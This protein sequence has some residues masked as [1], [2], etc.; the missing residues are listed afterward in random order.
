MEKQY[1]Y[2]YKIE[3]TL[4][5]KFYFGVHSTNNLEDNYF[6]S[7]KRL[8]YAIKKYGKENF[9]KENLLFFET[10]KQAFDYEIEIVNE[11]LLLDPS[12]YNLKV[13]GKGGLGFISDEQQLRRA[14]AASAAQRHKFFNDPIYHERR[15]QQLSESCKKRHK[16][17]DFD[18]NKRFKDKLHTKETKEL[19]GSKNKIN[20]SGAGNSQYGTCWVTNKKEN[21]KIHRGDLIPTGWKLG[22]TLE[23]KT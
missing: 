23:I 6:G 1:N 20:Q 19:I 11:A 9:I 8:K 17:G 10:Y 21:K 7:G 3:N 22:R 18:N 14:K 16:N 12:C 15:M 2:F 4:N 5:G 13:G